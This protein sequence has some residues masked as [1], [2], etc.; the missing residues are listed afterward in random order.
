G[1]ASGAN[2]DAENAAKEGVSAVEA[3]VR[4]LVNDGTASLGDGIKDLRRANRVHGSMLRGVE[5]LW[6]I[7]NNWRGVRHG[8]GSGP[9]LDGPEASYVMS[10]SEA[11]RRLLVAY[12]VT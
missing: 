7:T 9:R 8:G 3:L 11:V 5:E 2:V 1:L 12:D 4:I 10:L 6:A